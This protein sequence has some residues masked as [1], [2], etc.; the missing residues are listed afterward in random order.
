MNINNII[1]EAYNKWENKEYIFEKINNEYKSITYGDFIKSSTD[2]AKKLISYGLKDKKI[3]IYGKNSTDYMISDLAVLA[4]VGISVNINFQTTENELKEII[5]TMEIDAI[6]YD[7][8]KK[9]TI[10]LIKDEY[11]NI[12]FICMQEEIDYS[13]NCSFDFEDKDI[14]KC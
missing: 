5:K 10:D 6:L 3:I 9:E 2:L 12:K 4:Y 11:K 8:D 14:N 7:N 13:D 1:K